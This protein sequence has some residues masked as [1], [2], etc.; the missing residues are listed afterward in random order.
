MALS[1]LFMIF[2]NFQIF[3]NVNVFSDELHSEQWKTL[4]LH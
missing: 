4:Q 3:Y 1:P 2:S